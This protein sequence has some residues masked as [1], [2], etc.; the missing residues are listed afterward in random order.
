MGLSKN[1]F[2][3]DECMKK[4]L[5]SI[6]EVPLSEEEF[7]KHKLKEKERD[8]VVERNKKRKKGAP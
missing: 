8:E 4:L 7:E 6:G 5:G 1:A 3:N 2:N